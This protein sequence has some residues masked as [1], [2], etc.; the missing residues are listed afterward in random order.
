MFKFIPLLAIVLLSSFIGKAQEVR[1]ISFDE[2]VAIALEKNIQLRQEKN[3]LISLDAQKKQSAMAYLPS[4]GI[5]FQASRQDGQQFQLVEDGFEIKNVQA[6]RLSGGVNAD[7]TIFNGFGRVHSR[8]IASYNY[9]AQLKGVE[10]T[11]QEII[12]QIA[13][14]YLQVLL[15]KELLKIN[16]QAVTDQEKQLQQIEGFVKQG[17][18][19]Q[20][21]LYT[22]QAQLRQFELTAIESENQLEINKA[23][24]AQTLQL[25]PLEVF[26]VAPIEASDVA[27]KF[28][29]VDLSSAFNVALEN[30]VDLKQSQLTLAS[31]QRN[32][33]F[34]KTGLYPSLSAFYQYGTQYSSLNTLNFRD[35]F[36]DLYP[37]N[38]V[39]LS[40]NIPIFNNFVN[41]TRI[42]V[43]K[44]DLA[45]N[46]LNL[47][48]LK[49]TV[50]RDVQN[51]YLN[52]KAAIKKAE[53]TKIGVE[54]SQEAHEVQKERYKIGV[55]N[56]VELS[57]ANQALIKA[58]SDDAQAR[59]T[60]VF[61]KLILDFNT[62]TLT[63]DQLME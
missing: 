24:F 7:L 34:S 6:D 17:L 36:F 55:A 11:R 44:V 38:T 42:E 5:N 20:A 43:A 8:K 48:N 51:A 56:F 13:Q 62:G 39:G 19:P 52:F 45:N 46:S 21:D 27:I 50:Y 12:F 32:V 25:N 28:P 29:E 23:T 10:R 18:R 61:Q 54:A 35:Q 59:Y 60:L 2:A 3:Q 53:V 57:Q 22:Q 33:A 47:E 16:Q 31:A 63:A 1:V 4:A 15:D 41:R 26:E 9:E 30:R 37:N 14:Q 58:E 49:R 40:L